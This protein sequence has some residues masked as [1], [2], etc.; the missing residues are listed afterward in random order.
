MSAQPEGQN[1]PLIPMP[2][3]TPDD[4]RAAVA[5]LTPDQLDDF[6][7]TLRRAA[8]QAQETSSLSPL[9]TFTQR[10]AVHIAVQRWPDRAALLRELEYLAEHGSDEE[11]CRDAVT[12][13]GQLL[14]TAREEIAT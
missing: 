8:T 13:I 12:R 6:D 14:R 10:W 4:L 11:V 1:G 9:R 2:P 3:L 7:S 5:R